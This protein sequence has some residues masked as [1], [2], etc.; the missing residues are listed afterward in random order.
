MELFSSEQFDTRLIHTFIRVCFLFSCEFIYQWYHTVSRSHTFINLTFSVTQTG[1]DELL[2]PI[3]K[4]L[5]KKAPFKH[6]AVIQLLLAAVIQQWSSW[7]LAAAG[8]L[9]PT[10]SRPTTVMNLQTAGSMWQIRR[11]HPE[12]FTTPY[13]LCWSHSDSKFVPQCWCW[14][15][16]TQSC[17]WILTFDPVTVIY[18]LVW[19]SQLEGAL[20]YKVQL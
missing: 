7:L 17:V 3:M 19:G 4:W 5:I 10:V 20:R 12:E 18:S 2:V 9:L 8:S 16:E 6:E 14:N 11:I 1:S 13:W 15:S